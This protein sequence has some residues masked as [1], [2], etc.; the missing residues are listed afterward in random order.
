M[1]LHA[2]KWPRAPGPCHRSLA[3]LGGLLPTSHISTILG[4]GKFTH[5]TGRASHGFG[6]RRRRRQEANAV[7]STTSTLDVDVFASF[8]V[9]LYRLASRFGGQLMNQ[10]D[11]NSVP[12]RG[13]DKDPSASLPPRGL[14]R[15]TRR[16]KRESSMLLHL[17]CVTD[18]SLQQPNLVLGL[19]SLRLLT[20]SF[21]CRVHNQVTDIICQFQA[22]P[23]IG[24]SP[25]YNHLSSSRG[26]ALGAATLCLVLRNAH[27]DVC[28][29]L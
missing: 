10:L 5:Q 23:A 12:T 25:E 28:D 6:L 18:I 17:I 3:S 26:Y 13:L 7:C 21:N 1:Q 20:A 27:R 24:D 22:V 14:P 16:Q 29:A 11:D 2:R 15:A 4:G 19:R 8:D 9:R